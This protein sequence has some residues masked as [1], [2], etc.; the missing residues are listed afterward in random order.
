MDKK[1]T[2]S[3]D[4]KA[5]FLVFVLVIIAA[6]IAYFYLYLPLAERR[7]ELLVENHDLDN[8]RINLLNMA[9]DEDVF[10]LGINESGKTIKQVMNHYSAGNT[11]EK[12]IM[13]VERMEREVG[14]SLPSLSFSQPTVLSTVQMPMVSEDAEGNYNIEYYNVEL[15]HETLSTSYAC[16]YEQLKKMVDYI[17]AYPERMNIESISIAYDSENNGL[18]GNLTLNLY[19]VTGT[20]KEYTAPDISGLSMGTGNI[21]GQ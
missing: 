9:V 17:N 1:K 2:N 3:N 20:G 19:A 5:F 16:T 11:P 7:N 12:N 6:V 15:L 18:K 10:K 4:V 13:M 21:F 8:R 14:I